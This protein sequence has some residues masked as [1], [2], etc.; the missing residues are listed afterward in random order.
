MNRFSGLALLAKSAVATVLVVSPFSITRAGQEMVETSSAVSA[1]VRNLVQTNAGGR[2]QRM[3]VDG[4]AVDVPATRFGLPEGE[5]AFIVTLPQ[6]SLLDR[7]RFVNE[8]GAAEGELNVFASNHE[9]PVVSSRWSQIRSGVPFSH[10]P[11][12]DLPLV[13]VEARYVKLSFLARK[14]GVIAALSV[15][16][17][18][19]A[20]GVAFRGEG[21]TRVAN[22]LAA[23]RLS[24][25]KNFNFANVH[26]KARVVFVSSGATDTA[27]RMIDDNTATAFQFAPDDPRPTAIIELAEDARL[28]RVTAIHNMEAGKLEIYI[29]DKLQSDPEDFR[30]AKLVA[31]VT[32]TDGGGRAAVDFDAEGARYVALRWIPETATRNPFEFAEVGAFGE[33]SL[34]ILETMEAPDLYAESGAHLTGEGGVD[35][36]NKLGTLADPPKLAPVSP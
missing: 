25:T 20:A 30:A 11:V 17:G 24:D 15:S 10:S 34:S 35:F 5:T 32:E 6:T 4:H 33:A 21:A 31:S 26:A 19:L 9:L 8:K 27:R 3:T 23:K 16:G 2:I 14:P 12:F 7:L 1:D 36:S 22:H 29:A 28:H 13:G 18:D